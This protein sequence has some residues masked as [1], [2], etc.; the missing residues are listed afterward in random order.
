M[1]KTFEEYSSH[2]RLTKTAKSAAAEL[3]EAVMENIAWD[4]L[5]N[6]TD[7]DECDNEEIS[8]IISLANDDPYFCKDLDAELYSIK[9]IFQEK[10]HI[11]CVDVIEQWVEDNWN[12]YLDEDTVDA[13]NDFFDIGGIL[14]KRQLN[15]GRFEAFRDFQILVEDNVITKIKEALKPAVD[16]DDHD[17]DDDDEEDDD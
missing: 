14:G 4:F 8:W 9:E 3:A 13:L 15:G 5:K 10:K 17:D 6:A 16:K 1:I 12:E 2:N 11:R 7:I